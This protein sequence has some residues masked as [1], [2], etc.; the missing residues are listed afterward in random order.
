MTALRMQA[1]PWKKFFWE[2]LK[3]RG[4]L[5][6]LRIAETAETDLPGTEGTIQFPKQS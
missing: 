5:T 1:K 4:N 3:K 6:A 2:I